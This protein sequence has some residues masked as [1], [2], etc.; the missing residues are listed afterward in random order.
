MPFLGAEGGVQ[1]GGGRLGDS[2]ERKPARRASAITG[3]FSSNRNGT[4]NRNRDL[5][6]AMSG[7]SKN[8]RPPGATPRSEGVESTDESPLRQDRLEVRS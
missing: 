1:A 8:P 3:G 5:R 6:A 4:E 2:P 7:E